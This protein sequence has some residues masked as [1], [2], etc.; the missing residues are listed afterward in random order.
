MSQRLILILSLVFF[1]SQV[2]SFA[3]APAP[4]KAPAET[5]KQ[6]LKVEQPVAKGAE[7]K[8]K[9]APKAQ[10]VCACL[11]SAV[12]ALQK[13]YTSLEEDEWPTAI[14]VASDT[15]NTINSLAKTCKCP[16]V[17]FYQNIGKAYLNYAKAGNLLDGEEEPNCKVAKKLYEEAITWLET[18]I[19]KV[20]NKDVSSNAK[21]I[22]D[23]AKEELQFVKDECEEPESPAKQQ[24]STG[25]AKQ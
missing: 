6:P 11:E 3:Q 10:T 15:F 2:N 1:I 13:A 23:Y 16:E 14:K 7:L 24:K 9:A 12:S 18:S 4:E 21:S 19:S 22:Q 8:E 20:T 17:V 25:G 5:A